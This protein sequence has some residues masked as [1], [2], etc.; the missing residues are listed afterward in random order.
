MSVGSLTSTGSRALSSTA[1][2]LYAYQGAGASLP[3]TFLAGVFYSVKSLPPFW[4]HVSHLNP[5]FYMV[6]GFRYGFFG[7]SDVAPQNS[8]AVVVASFVAVSSLTLWLL[9][10]GWK[11]RA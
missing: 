9:K 5:F 8:L 6:D 10:R 1:E 3:A 4:Q 2:T 11:L 7:V